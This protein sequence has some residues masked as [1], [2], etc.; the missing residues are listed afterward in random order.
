MG[1]R[2]RA[3]NVMPKAKGQITRRVIVVLVVLYIGLS[4][5]G[6]PIAAAVA[7]PTVG[8]AAGA[9]RSAVHIPVVSSF[10]VDA[11]PS[12]APCVIGPDT[13]N[14]TSTDPT[15]AVDW[16]NYGDTTGCVFHY[17]VKWG[18][19]ATSFGD[20]SGGPAGS[21]VLRRHTYASPGTYTES[22]T[23]DVQ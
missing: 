1:G 10:S 16:T 4:G 12:S 8:P 7:S 9:A 17:L 18:D 20:V 5:A 21:Y 19:G 14:C 23:G 11:S 22:F 13:V 3:V 15:L 2:R 6:I